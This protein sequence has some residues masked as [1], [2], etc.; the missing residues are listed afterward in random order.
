[1]E[2]QKAINYEI[3]EWMEA[4]WLMVPVGFVTPAREM[5]RVGLLPRNSGG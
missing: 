2:M 1:M 3:L 4:L 5:L